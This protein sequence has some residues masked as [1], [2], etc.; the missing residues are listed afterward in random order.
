M[1]QASAV[2]N[3]GELKVF[4]F[5]VIAKHILRVHLFHVTVILFWNKTNPR[6]VWLFPTFRSE[7]Q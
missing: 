6:K 3:L 7:W 2:L 1:N 5:R 4:L